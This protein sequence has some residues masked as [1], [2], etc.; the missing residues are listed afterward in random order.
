MDILKQINDRI[1]GKF[2]HSKESSYGMF[3][4]LIGEFD[5]NLLSLIEDHEDQSSRYVFEKIW[6]IGSKILES[7]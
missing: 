6:H 5:Q 3:L 2:E 4:H 7:N 1:Y